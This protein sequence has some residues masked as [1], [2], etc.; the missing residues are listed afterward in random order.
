VR[1]TFNACASAGH[2]HPALPSGMCN[3]N[4]NQSKTLRHAPWRL[5][6]WD[7]REDT[8][9]IMEELPARFQG[10]NTR[11][12]STGRSGEAVRT[13]LTEA[14]TCASIRWS[15]GSPS[16]GRDVMTVTSQPVSTHRLH[17]ASVR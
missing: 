8:P 7:D 11:D 15:M 17:N 6:G 2:N 5:A 4:E 14:G 3:H 12:A 9:G 13:T 16:P 10:L 1:P